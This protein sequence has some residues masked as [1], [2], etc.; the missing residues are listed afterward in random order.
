MELI[1]IGQA[2]TMIVTLDR[3]VDGT[4]VDQLVVEHT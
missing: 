1:P 4:S 2:V 3:L